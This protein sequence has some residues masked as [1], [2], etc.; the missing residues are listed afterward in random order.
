VSNSSQILQDKA[1]EVLHRAIRKE[2]ILALPNPKDIENYTRVWSRDS[3]MA[4]LVGLDY[5]DA[6]LTEGLRRSLN[7]LRT[8]QTDNGIIPS[9]VSLG[10]EPKVS[11]GGTAGRVDATL[12]YIIGA[13]RYI[14]H[15]QD[16][17]FI[18][19]HH[20][21]IHQAVTT[22]TLW[23][24][25]NKHLI[26]TPLSGNWA[27]EYPIHGYTLYDNCLRL[28]GLE[29]YNEVF[30]PTAFQLDKAK[31]VRQTIQ[32]NFF[33]HRYHKG[34]KYNAFLYDNQ[35]KKS[36]YPYMLAGFNPA[37]YYTMFDTGGNGL[38]LMLHLLEDRCLDDFCVYLE[39]VFDEIHMQLMPA[40][41]PIIAEGDDLYADLRSNF[42]YSFKNEPYH[43]HNGGIWP[44]MNGWLAKGLMKN[45]KKNLVEKMKSAYLAF[46]KRE[47]YAFSEYIASDTLSP[48]GKSPLCYSATG[49]LMLLKP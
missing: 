47:Q 16:Q 43:F 33:L 40:F 30:T 20:E 22:C 4:G 19:E 11:Y 45:G 1:L 17:T 32:A 34:E 31:K 29:L 21:A 42:A 27:D 13:L 18:N 48:G 9:N 44:I 5:H 6:K 37:R 7:T 35:Q 41:W 12:W 26:Y 25:N 10:P 23:E 14:Q 49:A 2:G 46:A 36:T 39:S 8:H 28:W 3:I 15:T 24:F 38:A